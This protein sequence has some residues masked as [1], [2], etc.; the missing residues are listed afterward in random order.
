[1]GTGDGGREVVH[2]WIGDRPS[3][4]P[5]VCGSLAPHK[6]L[7]QVH[8]MAMIMRTYDPLWASGERALYFDGSRPLLEGG[9][10][11]VL[12]SGNI[13]K[14]LKRVECLKIF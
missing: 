9:R 5:G 12:P 14:Y 6:T 13:K 7:L 11:T 8:F 2:T 4:V 1:M 10:N 3:T